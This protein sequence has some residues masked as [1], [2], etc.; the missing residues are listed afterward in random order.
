M[1]ACKKCKIEFDPAAGESFC[2]KCTAEI[3]AIAAARAA[4]QLEAQRQ[5]AEQAAKAKDELDALIAGFSDGPPAMRAC[6]RLLD[7]FRED[8]INLLQALK[9]AQWAAANIPGADVDQMLLIAFKSFQKGS[10]F[11]LGGSRAR[12]FFQGQKLYRDKGE[13]D[14]MPEASDLDVGYGNLSVD[15]AAELNAEAA[16]QG[17]LPIEQF[18][19][20]PGMK[21]KKVPRMESPEEFFHRSGDRSDND[22]K[23]KI[24]PQ[25]SP[26]GS[27]TFAPNGE[28]VANPP[29]V[30]KRGLN[31]PDSGRKK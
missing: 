26:C 27:V 7:E 25:Y 31:I 8:P 5:R 16:R 28:I 4:K 21:T 13:S 2:P 24:E 3:A 17:P 23:S 29:D 14:V 20:V 11:V 1:A 22:P 12:S 6:P 10:S 19:I 30:Q 18:P 15:E 9:A